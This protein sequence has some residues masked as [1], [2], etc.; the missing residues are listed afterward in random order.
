MVSSHATHVLPVSGEVGKLHH[1]IAKLAENLHKFLEG[2]DS[3]QMV[4]GN[5][6]L[7]G[8]KRSGWYSE[9]P[10]SDKIQFNMIQ[11]FTAESKI[12]VF[13]TSYFC[14]TPALPFIVIMAHCDAIASMIS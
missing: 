5:Q 4:E 6:D 7:R 12:K 8:V 1:L 9:Q 11:S 14:V 2:A 13:L 10:V 3:F